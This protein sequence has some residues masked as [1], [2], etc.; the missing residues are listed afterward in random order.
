ME[1]LENEIER[2]EEE[3]KDLESCIRGQEDQIDEMQETIDN[4]ESEIKDLEYDIRDK[5][6]Q[7]SDLEE[8]AYWT[9]VEPVISDISLGDAIKIKELMVKTLKELGIRFKEINNG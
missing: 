4:L 1:E 3:I 8:M 9:G 6:D 5:E 7:I 2:Q